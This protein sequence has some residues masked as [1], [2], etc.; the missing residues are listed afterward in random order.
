[1]SLELHKLFM[2]CRNNRNRKLQK[3]SE[4]TTHRQTS[5]SYAWME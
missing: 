2:T 1:M 3:D 4:R 5:A